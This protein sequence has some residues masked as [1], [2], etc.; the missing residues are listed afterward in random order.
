MKKHIRNTKILTLFI[1]LYIIYL[2]IDIIITKN[3]P[4][5]HNGLYSEFYI[6]NWAY[7]IGG[8][9]FG[10]GIY[11]LIAIMKVKK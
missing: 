11:M 6:G 1:I 7:L 8:I 3:L 5:G 4:Q 9:I 2:G 10:F